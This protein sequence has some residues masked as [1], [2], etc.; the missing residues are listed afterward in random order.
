[1]ALNFSAFRIQKFYSYSTLMSRKVILSLYKQILRKADKFVYT[2]KEYFC[3]RVYREFYFN[4]KARGPQAD[5]LIQVRVLLG[6]FGRREGGRSAGC[7]LTHSGL[8]SGH[9]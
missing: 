6:L 3:D 7:I 4:R 2:D 9:F 1:M 5:R 8:V